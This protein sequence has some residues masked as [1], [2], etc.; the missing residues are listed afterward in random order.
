[1][2]STRIIDNEKDRLATIAVAPLM[3]C[4]ARLPVYV[5]LIGAFFPVAY[6]GLVLFSLYATG[7]VLAALVAW[8][9]R[10]TVLRGPRSVLMME[11]PVYQRPSLRVVTGQVGS[12]VREFLVLAGTVIFA[13]S[14]VIWALSYYPRP[15]EIHEAFE[16]KREAVRAELAPEQHEAALETLDA[17]EGAA[18]LEQSWLARGG[19]AMQP[20]FEPAGFDWRITVGILAAFPAREL[21]LPT[22]GVLYSI[23]EVDPGAYD[24]A[25]LEGAAEQPDGLRE[26]LRASMRP[27]GS[28]AFTPLVAL[29]LMVFFALCSQCMGTLAAIRRETR[30]WRW[31]V[32]VFSYMTVLAW[33]V[34][35]ALF[36][37][38]T[39][40]GLGGA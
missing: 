7:I 11:L 9:L 19:K 20:V 34:A 3:S 22:L 16:A 39:A 33:L 28:H 37:V 18:Y 4:S 8:A 25:S 13:T 10:R 15:A 27:D 21:I 24:V 26:T 2:L 30:S 14:V 1:V 17:A 29:G 35:V 12:A 32:F 5:V 6:A 36:Q 40:L 31:P 23:G 38:G